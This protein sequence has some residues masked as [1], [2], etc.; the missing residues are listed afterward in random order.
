MLEF[1]EGFFE[2]EIRDN[3]YVDVTMKTVWAAEMEVLQKVAEICD[4][5]GIIWY[6][7]Y[8][9]LLGAIRHE[10]F[11]PWDDDM[12]I[13]VKRND[14]N[15]LIQILP[16]ELPKGCYVRNPLLKEGYDEYH[17][18]VNN[19][20]G[21]S[22]NEKWLEQYHGCPFTVGLDIFPL[23]YLPREE[24]E[25]LVQEKLVSV[26][27]SCAQSAMALEGEKERDPAKRQSIT[28]KIR[29]GVRYLEDNF[30]AE[31]DYQLIEA[32]EWE[33]VASELWKWANY[34]AMMY[35][36]EESDF[37]VYYVDYV[38][39]PR[40]K[41]PK[42]WF[43]EVYSATFENFMLPVPCEY[44]QVLRLIYGDYHVC[45]RGSATHGYPFYEKQLEE[46]W[47]LARQRMQT[48]ENTVDEEISPAGWEKMIVRRDGT[49][50]K[51]VLYTNDISDFIT[52]GEEAL[53]KL[54]ATLQIFYEAREQVLLWWR[55]HK[56]MVHALTLIDQSA[57]ATIAG[58]ATSR[59]AVR[60]GDIL[61]QYKSAGWGVCDESGDKL[62]AVDTCD[63]YYGAKNNLVGKFQDGGKP[64]MVASGR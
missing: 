36:E 7:A 48:T 32:G 18:C 45:R 57:A 52:Y 64:V 29:E 47:K 39:W 23:D 51:I 15:K 43:A 12:D 38:R 6:A 53:D 13:W 8:G 17:T 24:E 55:P 20:N 26:A 14:Y 58:A 2:Q 9:T 25:R 22:T 35:G 1:Q 28:E 42:Q 61:E 21:I 44:D 11:V 34:F 10:G 27:V 63:A 3:F 62:R 49:R 31:I 46:L 41:Y 40:K 59:L 4:R 16:R 50:K 37:L 60:Y 19:G 5:Y 33:R 30:R 54:E 56:E